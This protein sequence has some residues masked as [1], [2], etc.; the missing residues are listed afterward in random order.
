MIRPILYRIFSSLITYLE[1]QLFLNLASLPLLIAWGLPFSLMTPVSNLFFNP[2]LFILLFLSSLIFFSE[3]FFLPNTF[4][5]TCL[6]KI[7][8]LSSIVFSWGNSSWLIELPTIHPLILLA[9]PLFSFFILH[10][11]IFNHPLKRIAGFTAT[12]IF[13]TA[14]LKYNTQTKPSIEKIACNE[15]ELTIMRANAKT[16]IIDPGA[17]GKRASSISWVEYT[18]VSHLISSYGTSTID[19]LIILQPNSCTL[20]AVARLAQCCTIKNIYLPYWHG[21]APKNFM[22]SYGMLRA[23]VN[24]H[25]T[26][27][28]RLGKKPTQLRI[29]SNACA[30]LVPTKS[31]IAYETISYPAYQVELSI[32]NQKIRI[33][34]LKLRSIDNQSSTN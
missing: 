33:N 23:A 10:S 15:N 3:L 18:L 34:S 7:S 6:E 25:E 19:H 26:T 4:L 29:G 22:R 27:I 31:S 8:Q 11:K 1:V 21:D 24:E 9:M 5:I 17:L 20:S 30:S 32:L 28:E 13:F 12:L 14:L 2:F 16:V